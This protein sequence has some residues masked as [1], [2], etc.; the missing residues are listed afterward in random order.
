MK[1]IVAFL[2]GFFVVMFPFANFLARKDPEPDMAGLSLFIFGFF[3]ALISLGS[4]CWSANR[5][6]ASR[7]ILTLVAGITCSAAFMS[8]LSFVGAGLSLFPA[9]GLSFIFSVLVATAS[10]RVVRSCT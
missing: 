6:P 7:S 8:P 5:M 1:R 10:P 4:F 2:T 9:L 3:G